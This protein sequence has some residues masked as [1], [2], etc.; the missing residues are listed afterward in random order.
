MTIHAEKDIGGGVQQ[1]SQGR[2]WVGHSVVARGGDGRRVRCL[3]RNSS[4]GSIGEC[5]KTRSAAEQLKSL[6]TPEQ[7]PR[8]AQGSCSVQ[9]G[10]VRCVRRDTFSVQC[11]GSITPLLC[12]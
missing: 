3:A 11:R 4:L 2:W 5:Q 1:E 9:E 12:G 10:E 6:Q 7:I 8:R